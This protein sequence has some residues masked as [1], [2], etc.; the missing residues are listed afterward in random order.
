MP[1][2]HFAFTS[3]AVRE[4]IG[5]AGLFFC[6]CRL[7]IVV[8]V[9]TSIALSNSGGLTTKS[10]QVVKLCTPHTS[11]LDQVNVIDDRRVK[12]EDPFN[13][14]TKTNLANGD[15]FSCT[16][17]FARNH[18]TLESLQSFFRFGFFDPDMYAN[19]IA[20]LKPRNVLPQLRLFNSV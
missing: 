11:P 8:L 4:L 17:M 15:R 1:A 19:R 6:R 13:S 18:N 10:S 9:S 12:W 3:C 7:A 14:N 20:R 16:A 2:P 5:L